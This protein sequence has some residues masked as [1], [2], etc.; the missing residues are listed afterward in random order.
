EAL[1]ERLNKALDEIVA[2]GTYQKIA[3][4]YFDFDIYQ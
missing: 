3:S 2:N 4:R 1:R